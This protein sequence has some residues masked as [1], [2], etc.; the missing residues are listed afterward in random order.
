[1]KKIRGMSYLLVFACWYVVAYAIAFHFAIAFKARKMDDLF[2]VNILI[3]VY[4]YII[5]CIYL[6]T[7][8]F[9]P[10]V[11]R[12]QLKMSRQ[13]HCCAYKSIINSIS[14]FKGNMNGNQVEGKKEMQ[15]WVY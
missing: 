2:K 9:V 3:M 12:W 14:R 1:M 15:D 4:L 13:M 6:I 8:F 5:I 7:V 11:N 10:I